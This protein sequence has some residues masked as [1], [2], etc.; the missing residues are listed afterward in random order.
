MLQL[1][2]ELWRMGRGSVLK[3]VGERSYVGDRPFDVI[4]NALQ[5]AQG[6]RGARYARPGLRQIWRRAGW[7]RVGCEAPGKCMGMCSCVYGH[8]YFK[9]LWRCRTTGAQLTGPRETWTGWAMCCVHRQSTCLR[10]TQAQRAGG[11]LV[12]DPYCLAGQLLRLPNLR[13]WNNG[14]IDGN[15][16][17]EAPMTSA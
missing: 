17:K 5:D 12:C 3:A 16:E 8:A 9:V 1:S 4:V 2:R 7:R 11:Q 10:W 14:N 13:V 15:I 6:R